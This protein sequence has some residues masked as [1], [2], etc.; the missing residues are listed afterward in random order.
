MANEQQQT[1]RERTNK[2]GGDGDPAA[3]EHTN[4]QTNKQTTQGGGDG[5]PAA[6]RRRIKGKGKGKDRD[7]PVD[8][9]RGCFFVWG[10]NK[11]KER[12]RGHASPRRGLLGNAANASCGANAWDEQC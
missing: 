2:G 9:A 7:E 3:N 4:K 6:K 10:E 1:T 5:D 8:A 12:E 11:T